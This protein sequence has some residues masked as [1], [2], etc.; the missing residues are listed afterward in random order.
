MK[1]LVCSFSF[2]PSVRDSFVCSV[3]ALRRGKG[4]GRGGE[5]GEEENEQGERGEEEREG[6]RKERGGKERGKKR[7]EREEKGREGRKE[8]RGK[9]RGEREEKGREGR[10]GRKKGGRGRSVSST[11]CVLCQEVMKVSKTVRRYSSINI[12]TS[13]MQHVRPSN[14]QELLIMFE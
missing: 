11:S 5:R 13:T 12:A 1:F 3:V 14:N 7:G 6:G 8:E 4:E 10:E 2:C 9:K